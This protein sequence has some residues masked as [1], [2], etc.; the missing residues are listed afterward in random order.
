M[1]FGVSGGLLV[2]T[3]YGNEIKLYQCALTEQRA[4]EILWYFGRAKK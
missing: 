1:R 3:T 2:W 4:R